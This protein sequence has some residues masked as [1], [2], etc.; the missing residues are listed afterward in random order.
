MVICVYVHTCTC[1]YHL[2]IHVHI[3]S[4]G[5]LQVHAHTSSGWLQVHVHIKIMPIQYTCTCSNERIRWYCTDIHVY[6][7]FNIQVLLLLACVGEVDNYY[8]LFV[9][10][11]YQI[12]YEHWNFNQCTCIHTVYVR[13][14]FKWGVRRRG[15][16]AP[17]EMVLVPPGSPW[18][19]I[20]FTLKIISAH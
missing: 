20:L 13:G 19:L 6:V 3:P 16:L 18:K 9:S 2:H 11:Y 12:P 8:N 10:V 4:S 14:A 7:L 17:P 1:T 5:W 15:A